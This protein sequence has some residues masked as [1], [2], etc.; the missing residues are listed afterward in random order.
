MV[1]D[2]IAVLKQSK[3]F[4]DWGK[5]LLT[6]EVHPGLMAEQH[7]TVKELAKQWGVSPD[8]IRD[9]FK[10]RPGVLIFKRPGTRTKR[11]YSTMRIPESIASQV[12]S[13]LSGR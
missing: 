8:L 13:E 12:Y 3:K 10:D 1:T 2:A 7:Y 11:A 6:R 9:I 4:Q 5:L